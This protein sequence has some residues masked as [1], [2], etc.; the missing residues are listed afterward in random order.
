M[1]KL[2]ECFFGTSAQTLHLRFYQVKATLSYSILLVAYNGGMINQ[3]SPFF[4]FFFQPELSYWNSRMI[5]SGNASIPFVS[6]SNSLSWIALR[7]YLRNETVQ[8]YAL[9]ISRWFYTR[10]WRFIG[11]S[12]FF[13]S[14]PFPLLLIILLMCATFLYKWSDGWTNEGAFDEKQF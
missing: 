6:Q 8:S 12:I 7:K 1:N 3:D 4:F 2:R 5:L 10:K 14:F 11:I 9:C 13:C